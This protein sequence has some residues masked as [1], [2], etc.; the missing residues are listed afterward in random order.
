MLSKDW[1]VSVYI[2]YNI[3]G[4]LSGMFAKFSRR[5][6]SPSAD[7]L[8]AELSDL[9]RDR[10]LV[11]AEGKDDMSPQVSPMI[12]PSLEKLP[13]DDISQIVQTRKSSVASISSFKMM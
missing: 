1:C 10:L 4:R 11:P 12:S 7:I 2:S 8:S 9:K 5:S 13:L 3:T 6:P